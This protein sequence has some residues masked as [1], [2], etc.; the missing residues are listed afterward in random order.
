M[1]IGNIG[2][3]AG[4]GSRI[5]YRRLSLGRRAN[6][7]FFVVMLLV[8][9]AA[10]SPYS[11]QKEVT[12]FSW[13][14]DHLSSGFANGFSALASDRQAKLE[15]DLT[16]SLS[17]VSISSSC[18]AALSE[19]PPGAAPC[20]L[21]PTGTT[22]P[23][24]TDIEKTRNQTTSALNA[25]KNYAD[26]L[27]AVT[28]AADR[29]AF[30]NAASQLS[31]SVGALA[32]TAGA[33]V[34]GASILAPVTT[35]VLAWLVGTALDQQRFDTLKAAVD[36]VGTASLNGKSTISVVATTMGAG[37]YALRLPFRL[38]TSHST[39]AFLFVPL[40]RRRR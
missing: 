35:N 23:A 13:G 18:F 31:G 22:P 4:T 34:P 20:E 21:F 12:S 8:T 24:L 25:L 17:K 38:A 39:A 15:L 3:L 27:A 14:V 5:R 2:G 29:T 16:T 19:V 30:N 26:A 11:F 33:V 32:K 6:A 7:K 9:L 28:N 36:L 40:D 10:C 37:F 1:S